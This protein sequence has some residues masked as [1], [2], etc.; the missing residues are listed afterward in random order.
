VLVAISAVV[1]AVVLSPYIHDVVANAPSSPVRPTDS[2]AAADAWSFLVPPRLTF[3]GQT[4]AATLQR[5]TSHPVGNGLGYLGPAALAVL[6]GF[7]IMEW[8]RRS[9][10]LLLG[11]VAIG[12]VLTMGPLLRIGGVVHGRLPGDVLAHLP[13]IQSAVPARFAMYVSLAV[14]VILA[15]WL[16]RASGRWGWVRWVIGIAAVISFLPQAPAHAPPQIVP[17]FLTSQAMHDVLHPHENVYAIVDEKG[18]EMLWQ[19]T[20]DYWF[21]IAQGYIGPLP[22]SL[23]T[24][25]MSGGLHLRRVKVVPPA[26]EFQTW[27]RDHQVTAVVVDDRALPSYRAMLEGSNMS[28]VY[29]GEGVSVWRPTE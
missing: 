22:P 9:T 15:L 12:S 8:K 13:L 10:W 18:D 7:A 17:P 28:M 23:R 29:E 2:M 27:T 4:Y 26:T 1:A 6:I 19:A 3:G 14:G 5:L 21:D 25:P 20:A 11:F 16:A 24:G